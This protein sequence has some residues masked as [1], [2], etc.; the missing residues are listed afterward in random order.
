MNTPFCNLYFSSYLLYLPKCGLCIISK[1]FTGPIA[2]SEC[3]HHL[4]HKNHLQLMFTLKFANTAHTLPVHSSLFRLKQSKPTLLFLSLHCYDEHS[5][6]ESTAW[7]GLTFLKL[8]SKRRSQKAPV[9]AQTYSTPLIFRWSRDLSRSLSRV[10]VHEAASFTKHLGAVAQTHIITGSC[11]FPCLS[12][13]L[14]LSPDTWEYF[15]C[16]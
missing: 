14:S 3:Y 4:S 7:E 11:C 12:S 6:Q 5:L 8:N 1:L 13:L 2:T 9:S 16:L 10:G 15:S